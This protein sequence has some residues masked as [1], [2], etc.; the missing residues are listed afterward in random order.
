MGNSSNHSQPNPYSFHVN[1]YYNYPKGQINYYNNNYNE[2]KINSNEVISSYKNIS[3]DNTQKN[4]LKPEIENNYSKTEKNKL[5][6]EENL[7]IDIDVINKNIV[8]V[9][10]PVDGSK[11]WDKQY[12]KN[13]LIGKI[14][15]DYI[16]DNKLNLNKDSFNELRC[17]KYKVSM[18]DKI[19]TLLPIDDEST[20]IDFYQKNNS[21]K[22]GI[23]LNHLDEKYTEIMGK[24]FFGP[25]E[26]LCFYKNE[27]KFKILKFSNKII[28]KTKVN[29]FDYS[30]AYCNG[31]NHIYISGGQ[32]CSTKFWSI[33][34]KKNKINDPI[35]IYPKQNHSMIFIPKYIV[36]FVGG[37]NLET[38][39]YHLK[40]KYL[41]KWGNLNEI[42]TEPGLQ[43]IQNKLYCI[44]NIYFNKGFSLEVTDLTYSEGG[45]WNLIKPKLSFNLI[46]N[47]FPQH[48]F[49]ICK[50]K[51]DNIIFLGGEF[52]I[53]GKNIK[54]YIFNTKNNS[55]DI[56]NVQFKNFKLKEK[57][58]CPFNNA[59]DFILTDFQRDYPQMAFYNKKKGK[60]ELINFST[61][62]I[63][64]KSVSSN[65][66]GNF[67]NE[68]NNK[69][70]LDNISNISP[71]LPS[72]EK[73]NN[74]QIIQNPNLNKLDNKKNIT[75]I[76]PTIYPRNN[77][78]NNINNYNPLIN[79]SKNNI[80]ANNNTY[81]K[82][83][84]FNKMNNNI[85]NNHIN[86]NTQINNILLKNKNN[87]NTANINNLKD[88]TRI[89][90]TKT[91]KYDNKILPIHYPQNN[92]IN[93][94]TYI[95]SKE[96]NSRID[97]I[98][99]NKIYRMNYPKYS[100]V[101][102]NTNL[103]YQNNNIRNRTPEYLKNKININSKYN[104]YTFI[105]QMAIINNPNKF[106]NNYQNINA[107]N[108]LRTFTKFGY[109]NSSHSYD[110][111]QKKYYYPK[112]V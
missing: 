87:I 58:F 1:S 56:S 27:R 66:L 83:E 98:N 5:N 54:N 37:Q 71:I 45:R 92:K 94:N 64:K 67:Q 76:I 111:F 36:F 6:K 32:N 40:E 33:N 28:E 30:S 95:I 106:V 78:I 51:N 35:E 102:N 49:G 53:K 77:D 25:F 88:N 50:D 82:I 39:Y 109:R 47:Q 101:N 108:N 46:N 63:S 41:Y 3:L 48:S 38:F 107:Y 61:D 70:D 104:T 18:E 21:E 84:T 55:I 93:N 43:I 60:I 62:D 96:S 44:D 99:N 2:T 19:S 13:E 72:N 22:K 79:Y 69:K 10:I 112:K 65:E 15:N 20:I 91:I 59:F 80:N 24:P 103:I 75:N 7:S 57:A 81:N 31:W 90:A 85:I 11:V 42:R 16:I 26:I 12:Y 9:K 97:N 14:I 23:D 68:M 29:V 100:F 86:N 52:S 17:N 74:N 105:N 89:S 110:P 73:D 34:L 8:K 4:I